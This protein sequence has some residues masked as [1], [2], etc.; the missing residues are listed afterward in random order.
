MA[1]IGTIGAQLGTLG[2]GGGG[3]ALGATFDGGGGGPYGAYTGYKGP[4]WTSNPVVWRVG[5]VAIALAVGAVI[6]IA[7]N[8]LMV[9]RPM[10]CVTPEDCR[11]VARLNTLLVGIKSALNFG[12]AIVLVFVVLGLAGVDARGLLVSAGVLSLVIGLGAQSLIKSFI[13]GLT[14]LS[15][16]RLSLGDYVALDVTGTLPSGGLGGGGG[17]GDGHSGRANTFTKGIVR[18]FSLTTT[19]LEDM[20]GARTFIPNG[21]IIMVTNFS[22]QPQ[23][24]TVE[25]MVSHDVN[26]AALRPKLAQFLETV[27]LDETLRNQVLQPPVLKGIVASNHKGYTV[28][29]TA[30]AAPAAHLMVERHLRERVLG[31]LSA[32][33]AL[34]AMSQVLAVANGGSG[35]GSLG[36]GSFGSSLAASAA[37]APAAPAAPAPVL[38]Q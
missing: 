31:F 15:A 9:P 38:P 36:S 27:A 2:P 1:A 29:V 16:D 35:S 11:A 5:S 8:L 3:G 14:L 37:A 19:T 10:D 12:V 22:Q 20:Q 24:A 7:V 30:L 26:P 17:G 25:F 33:H 32:Q 28:T 4:K 18:G 13:A 23:R 6:L 34:P 21:N